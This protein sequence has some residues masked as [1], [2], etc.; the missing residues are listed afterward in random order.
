KMCVELTQVIARFEEAVLGSFSVVRAA[1]T[2][3][4]PGGSVHGERGNFAVLVLLCI[5]ASDSESG[6]I[7]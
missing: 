1:L 5:G 4:R 6:L 7:F 3:D 2:S